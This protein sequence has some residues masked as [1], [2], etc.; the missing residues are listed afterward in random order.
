ML[1]DYCCFTAGNK[2]ARFVVKMIS[3]SKKETRAKTA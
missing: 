1:V 2:N 3:L